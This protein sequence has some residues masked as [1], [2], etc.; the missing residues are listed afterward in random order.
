ML[1]VWQEAV[2]TSLQTEEEFLKYV[3]RAVKCEIYN[4]RRTLTARRR[5]YRRVEALPENVSALQAFDTDPMGWASFNEVMES[6][7]CQLSD[8]NW[9]IL[10]MWLAGNAWV[11]IGESFGQ[12][13][14]ALRKRFHRSLAH[15]RQQLS[16]RALSAAGQ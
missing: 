11:T 2:M 7:R 4:L 10:D 15:I 1:R 16:A 14:E 9:Q 6:I 8:Q 12:D 5:D 13:A 3:S